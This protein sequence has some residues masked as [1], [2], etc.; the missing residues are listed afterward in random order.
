MQTLTESLNFE[1][2]EE[3][4]EFVSSFRRFLKAEI[5]PHILKV[6]KSGVPRSHFLALGRSGYTGLLHETRFG[7][8]DAD[9]L[10]T[11]LAQIELG[12]VCGSTFFSAGAS[13]GLYGLPLRYHGT[14]SQ[15]QRLLPPLIRGELIG[16]L[17]VTEPHSGSDVQ[18][19]Q[20][21]AVNHNGRILLKGHKTYI[22]NAPIADRSLVL[23]RYQDGQHSRGLTL[24]EVDLHADGVYR[25]L[26]FEK[27]GLRGSM[28]GELTFDDVILTDDSIVGSPGRGFQA[29]MQVFNIERLS[30][31]AYAAGV[32]RSCL[33]DSLAF[34]RSRKSSGKPLYKHQSVAF[35][36]ADMKIELD[37]TML[38][39]LE[40]AYL[41]DR[42][43]SQ[44]R[45][46][47]N[48]SII[49]LS[50]RA[51]ALKIQ[52]SEAGRKVAHL[53]VQVHGGAG[54]ME[55]YRVC[56]LYRDIRIAEIGGGTTEIQKQIVARAE[57]KRVN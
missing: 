40:T 27:M 52:A 8:T 24:F 21:T 56:R 54:Y 3:Q 30:M 22:T 20:S 33:E 25:S 38:Y 16:C 2:T 49:D 34:S 48:G 14:E 32:M 23:A 37:A 11:V 7:G 10:T 51:S 44:Q 47:H 35:M 5:E 31:A 15:K 41:F 4:R 53:A 26:P 39:L 12:S 6:E 57:A 17:A 19:V 42:A 9:H 50:A 45:L 36:L 18:A 55:E 13:A 43:G 1:L 46:I 29:V 28:T